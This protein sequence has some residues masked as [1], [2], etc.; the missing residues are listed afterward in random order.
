MQMLAASI[1]LEARLYAASNEL[2]IFEKAARSVLVRFVAAQ[3][4]IH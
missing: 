1:T 4:I 2:V 3:N